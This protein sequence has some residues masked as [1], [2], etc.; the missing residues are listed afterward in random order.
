MKSTRRGYKLSS[1]EHDKDGT[2]P[3]DME[4]G[5]SEKNM[6]RMKEFMKKKRQNDYMALLFM[7]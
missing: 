4:E 1:R 5:V 2:P 3:D 7:I 6:T